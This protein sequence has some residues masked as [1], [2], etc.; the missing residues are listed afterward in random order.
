MSVA[1]ALQRLD[2]ELCPFATKCSCCCRCFCPPQ[3]PRKAC[4]LVASLTRASSHF[5]SGNGRQ[6]SVAK[7]IRQVLKQ[8]SIGVTVACC[9][10]STGS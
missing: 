2:V 1:T 5:H 9:Q 4:Q 6:A 10:L 3:L 7:R 8:D